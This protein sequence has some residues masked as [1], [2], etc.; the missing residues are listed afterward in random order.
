MKE[1]IQKKYCNCCGKELCE[2]LGA[3]REDWV[4]FTKDWGYFSQKD[5][6]RHHVRLCERCYD[7]WIEQ[8]VRPVVRE[9]KTEW[10]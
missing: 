8:F 6:E 3:D 5:G 9:E 2:T 10:L 4:E 7:K 1:K